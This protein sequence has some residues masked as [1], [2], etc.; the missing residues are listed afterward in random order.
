MSTDGST[1]PTE[2]GSAGGVPHAP[3]A[4][5]TSVGTT[6]VP[7]T[8]TQYPTPDGAADGT[9]TEGTIGEG[10]GSGEPGW[11]ARN[12]NALIAA[13]LVV[14]VVALAI[15]AVVLYRNHRDDVNADTEAAVTTFLSG[16]NLQVETIECSGDT[17]AVIVG[18]QAAT[19]L[20]Q[21]DDKGD[22]HFGVSA[23]SGN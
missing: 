14:I 12:T 18:G 10:A 17:C 4:G 3:T 2:P 15:A 1:H 19:V 7:G 23:Y 21:E 8:T 6:D 16:Q 11:V 13:L 22:Q 20:V 5:A 9:T